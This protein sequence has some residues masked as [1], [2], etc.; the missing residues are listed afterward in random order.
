MP[1]GEAASLS[2]IARVTVALDTRHMVN[3]Q[4]IVE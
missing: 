4:T 3:P 1:R 2:T